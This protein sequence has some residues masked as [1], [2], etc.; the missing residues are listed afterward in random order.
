MK[1]DVQ[2]FARARDLAGAPRVAIDVPESARVSDLKNALGT[3]FPDLSPLLPNLLI[4]VD[5]EYANDQTSLAPTSQVA[6]F[7]PV[8]GG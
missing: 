8:S 7:P 2:L 4:A 5:M 3:R 6:C 1:V